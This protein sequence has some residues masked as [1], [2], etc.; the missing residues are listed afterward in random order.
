MIYPSYIVRRLNLSDEM[1]AVNNCLY[2]HQ[3]IMIS[4]IQA[5]RR[6]A[7]N[8]RQLLDSNQLN[9][10]DLARRTGERRQRIQ[11]LLAQ[12]RQPTIGVVARIAEALE[13]SVDELI[14]DPQK[15]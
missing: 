4:D 12:S 11:Q 1:V 2:N 6:I 9:Q 5:K 13:V 14:A 10:S 8:V 3:M 7:L 15:K